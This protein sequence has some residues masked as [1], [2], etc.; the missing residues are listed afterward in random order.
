MYDQD[1]R[2]WRSYKETK[3]SKPYFS[4]I[5]RLKKC[6]IGNLNRRLE[7]MGNRKNGAREGDMRVFVVRHFLSSNQLAKTGFGSNRLIKIEENLHTVAAG[8]RIDLTKAQASIVQGLT[9]S[10]R[11]SLKQTMEYDKH[12]GRVVCL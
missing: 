9:V 2:S 6:F 11:P 8:L 12:T 4:P 10:V 5:V 1:H 7:V 3:N